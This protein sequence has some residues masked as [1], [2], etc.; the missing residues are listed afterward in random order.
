MDYL[1]RAWA[2]AGRWAAGINWPVWLLS[3]GAILLIVIL[4]AK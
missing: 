4:L 3:V 1:K 2:E